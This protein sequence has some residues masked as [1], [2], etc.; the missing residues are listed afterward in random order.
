M[1]RARR[2]SFLFALAILG[3]FIAAATARAAS[4]ASTVLDGPDGGLIV[5][6][7]SVAG[8]FQTFDDFDDYQFSGIA[9]DRFRAAIKRGGG[10]VQPVLSAF[11]PETTTAVGDQLDFTLGATGSFT[12]R[13]IVSGGTGNPAG[14]PVQQGGGGTNLGTIAHKD[15]TLPASGTYQLL[16]SE[17][18]FSSGGDYGIE[19]VYSF[20]GQAGQRLLFNQVPFS[21]S[22]TFGFMTLY[23]PTDGPSAVGQ[24][25]EARLL[26]SGQYLLVLEHGRVSGD[27]TFAISCTNLTAGPVMGPGDTGGPIGDGTIYAGSIVSATETDACF[28]HASPDQA[29]TIDAVTQSGS[30]DTRMSIYPPTGGP[31]MQSSTADHVNFNAPLEGTYTLLVEDGSGI[32]TGEYR[33]SFAGGEAAVG[34]D[35]RGRDLTRVALADRRV[36]AGPGRMVWDGRDAEGR[37]VPAG[38]YFAT[39]RGERE[40]VVRKIARI[41]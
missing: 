18:N 32:G 39:I 41:E 26:Q 33:L 30:L 29:F 6:G 12:L 5:S 34:V 19:Y 11:G 1:T 28:F 8:A 17:Y 40:S 20:T 4:P 2:R 27:P 24:R 25:L 9:G 35:P 13:V 37:R 3:S 38:L 14:F 22:L 36:E 31:A 15:F 7:T 10:H 16:L 21:N 23:G